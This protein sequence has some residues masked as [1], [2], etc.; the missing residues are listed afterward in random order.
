MFASWLSWEC[1]WG[2]ILLVILFKGGEMP[3]R[4]LLRC[5]PVALLFACS[6][7]AQ[8]TFDVRVPASAAIFAAGQSVP[9]SGTLPPVVTFA[10]GS[11][12][13]ITVEASGMITLG[14]GEPY[15]AP[16]GIAFPGGTGLSSLNG[17]SGIIAL[18]RGF[19]LRVYSW[20]IRFPP[21]ADRQS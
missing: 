17:R 8:E 16:A 5:A 12:E 21:A 11:V 15:S 1:D 9:F 2:V 10:A 7:S 14:A 18:D 3:Y 6:A 4:I 19:F 13:A 20:T